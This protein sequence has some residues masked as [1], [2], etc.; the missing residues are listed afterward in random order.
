MRTQQES[1]WGAA[2]EAPSKS[3]GRLQKPVA[4]A[5]TSF[6]ASDSQPSTARTT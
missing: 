4:V 1:P 3:G 5:E 2:Q 6:E